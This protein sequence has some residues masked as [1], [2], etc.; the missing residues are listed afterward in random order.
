MRRPH[1]TPGE[2]RNRAGMCCRREWDLRHPSCAR[3]EP[4]R[5]RRR[6]RCPCHSVLRRRR[7]LVCRR[8]L[9]PASVQS[10]LGALGILEMEGA[11]LTAREGGN[12]SKRAEVDDIP[13]LVSPHCRSAHAAVN[14]P[15]AVEETSPSPFRRCSPNPVSSPHTAF[16]A[17]TVN[18]S[19][20]KKGRD[21]IQT[22]GKHRLRAHAVWVR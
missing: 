13:L 11:R 17:S 2:R 21:V 7:A 15:C 5:T 1:H 8:Y 9:P 4:R 6:T 14:F 16:S 18:S 10:W 12:V 22:T 19:T 20:V 3:L